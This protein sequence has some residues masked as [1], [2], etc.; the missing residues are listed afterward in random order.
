MPS[1]AQYTAKLEAYAEGKDPLAM[2]TDTPRILAELIEG[3]PEQ[4]LR[5]RPMPD[6]WSAGEII[7]HLA[8][9]ELTSSWRY[10]QMIE[11]SGCAL[12]AFNQDEWA[13]L[14]DYASWRPADALQLF[15]LLREANLRMLNR[16]TDEEW[17]RFGLHAERGRISVRDLA[18]HMAG[19]DMNH[20]DQVRAIL[21]KA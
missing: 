5:R 15:R 1:P 4:A 13:R 9:D 20:L 8:E 16:L 17:N 10:R 18:R 7:A 11:N 3:A 14:G 2:Q 12:P 21:A 19:H 6:K